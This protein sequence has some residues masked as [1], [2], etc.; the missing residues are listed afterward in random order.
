MGYLFW[1][2]SYFTSRRPPSVSLLNE[3]SRRDTLSFA[4]P[5]SLLIASLLYRLQLRKSTR[6]IKRCPSPAL[7]Y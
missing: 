5:L 1:K 4:R 6:H 3:V 7:L 2:S